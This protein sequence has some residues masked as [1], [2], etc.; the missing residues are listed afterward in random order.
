MGVG[1]SLSGLASAVANEGGVGVISA[2]II[3]FAESDLQTNYRE[4]NIRALRREIR[5]ARELTKGVLGVNIMVALTNFSDMVKTAVEEGIDI[6]FCG[7][8]LPL[9]LPA[10][11]PEQARSKLAPIVSSARA[12]RVICKRWLSRFGRLPD[13]FV[14]EG[15]MAG[16]HLGFSR[17]QV[18]DPGYSLPKLLSQVVEAV[19]PF[20]RDRGVKLPIIAAGGIYNGQDIKD[21]L[22]QGAAGVQLGT[23]FVTT[24]ECDADIKFKQAYMNAQEEDLVIIDSPVGLPGRSLHNSFLDKVSQGKKK[25]FKCP[26][27]CLITC[28]QKDSPYCIAAALINAVRGRLE[29]GFA[30]A[31]QNAFRSQKLVSVKNLIASLLEEFQ[32]AK[33]ASQDGLV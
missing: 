13:A 30:F 12:A 19:R 5:K 24:H 15:P 27:H 28:K 29:K 3:G 17:D 10:M 33:P 4:A 21:I 22:S 18:E 8:G 26:Y 20:E 14:L 31:G 2:A 16:G 25:P 1:I 7:A 6:I 9:D 32:Q 23:R 11:V